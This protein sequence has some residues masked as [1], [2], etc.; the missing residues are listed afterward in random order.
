MR[1]RDS[2][3]FSELSDRE[4]SVLRL[5]ARGRTNRQIADNLGLSVGRVRN[6]VGTLLNKLGLVDRTQAALLAYRSG[7]ADTPCD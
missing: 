4:Q 3:D 2:Y 1:P 6:I 5:L 7:L